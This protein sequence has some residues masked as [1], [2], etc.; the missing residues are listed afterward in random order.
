MFEFP[1]TM[2]SNVNCNLCASGVKRCPNGSLMLRLR[3]PTAELWFLRKP[4]L[5]EAFLAVV[6]MGIVFVQNV[7][8]LEIWQGWKYCVQQMLQKLQYPLHRLYAADSSPHGSANSPRPSHR[9]LR[10]HLWHQ[11]LS[12]PTRASAGRRAPARTST[13]SPAPSS[14]GA[15]STRRRPSYTAPPPSQAT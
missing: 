12:P 14:S 4:K 7:R 13:G 2:D 8:L 10:P 3:K 11:P 5:E 6:I 9:R 1:R 15:S